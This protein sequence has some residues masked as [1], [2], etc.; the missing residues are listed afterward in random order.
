MTKT[1]EDLIKDVQTSDT[2]DAKKIIEQIRHNTMVLKM[3]YLQDC[4]ERDRE[5]LFDFEIKKEL[6]EHL[7]HS[8]ALLLQLSCKLELDMNELWDTMVADSIQD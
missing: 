6:Q 7:T 5:W 3:R 2:M 4:N 1:L 8:F